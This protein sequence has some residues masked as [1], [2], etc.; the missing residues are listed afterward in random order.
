MNC[1]I[2]FTPVACILLGI[3][4]YVTTIDKPHFSVDVEHGGVSLWIDL[5][6]VKV[7]GVIELISR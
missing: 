2:S 5:K 6:D 4:L 1:S 3:L 7:E